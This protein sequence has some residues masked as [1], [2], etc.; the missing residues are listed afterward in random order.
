MAA[1][2]S[3]LRQSP[4]LI[5][6][7]PLYGGL[8][9]ADIGHHT[10]GKHPYAH[11]AGCNGFPVPYLIQIHIGPIASKH[12]VFRDGFV[13]GHRYIHPRGRCISGRKWSGPFESA[14]MNKGSLISGN[15]GPSSSIFF[16]SGIGHEQAYGLSRS[17]DPHLVKQGFTL[18]AVF[19]NS[20]VP[21][22]KSFITRMG[23]TISRAS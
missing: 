22:P 5:V 4:A 18:P 9:D 6:R 12:F 20:R 7:K 17:S 14:P 1:V 10:H 15:R 13:P 21:T 8:P 11:M 16:R 2:C 23:N 3:T 19:D